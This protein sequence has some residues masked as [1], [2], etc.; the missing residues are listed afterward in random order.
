MKRKNNHENNIWIVKTP[1]L[2]RSM[3]MVVTDNLD[4]MIRLLETGPKIA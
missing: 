1:N 3:D 4:V 2:A